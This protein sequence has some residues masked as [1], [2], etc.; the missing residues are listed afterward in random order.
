MWTP[1]RHRSWWGSPQWQSDKKFIR[2]RI[3]RKK[4]LPKF[5]LLVLDWQRQH[6]Y[7]MWGR[8]SSRSLFIYKQKTSTLT[9]F[10]KP[11]TMLNLAAQ[12]VFYIQSYSPEVVLLIG[13]LRSYNYKSKCPKIDPKIFTHNLPN[14]LH[15]THN[16]VQS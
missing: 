7:C 3:V 8:L 4:L 2:T 16:Y 6:P 10:V 13:S 9:P 14:G 11:C 12:N 15:V 1:V 5:N